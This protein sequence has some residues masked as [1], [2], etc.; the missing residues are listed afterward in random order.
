MGLLGALPLVEGWGVR[1]TL[2]Q[3][4]QGILHVEHDAGDTKNI[5]LFMCLENEP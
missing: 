1:S 2:L 3:P 4:L 5:D